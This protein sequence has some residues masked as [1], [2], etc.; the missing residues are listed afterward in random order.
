MN[1]T[2]INRDFHS[3]FIIAHSCALTIKYTLANVRHGKNTNTT[4]TIGRYKFID[5]RLNARPLVTNKSNIASMYEIKRY[6][7]L[8]T[9]KTRDLAR[10]GRSFPDKN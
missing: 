9:Q 6:L 2:P 4:H 1:I 3:L 5:A 7:K 10:R 8:R